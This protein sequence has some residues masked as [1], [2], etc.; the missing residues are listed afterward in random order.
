MDWAYPA[1]FLWW[2]VAI[3]AVPNRLR[4]LNDG[5]TDNSTGSNSL[6]VARMGLK[7][8]SMQFFNGI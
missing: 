2:Q 1:R 3:S 4:E 7:L 8:L 5:T 6:K